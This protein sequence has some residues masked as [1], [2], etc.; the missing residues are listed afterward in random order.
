MVQEGE[1]TRIYKVAEGVKTRCK[2]GAPATGGGEQDAPICT[3][4]AWLQLVCADGWRL[5]VAQ[6][7]LAVHGVGDALQEAHLLGAQGP[8][9]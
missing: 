2:G 5:L 4:A 3:P 9:N 1:G 7:T 6:L 8:L